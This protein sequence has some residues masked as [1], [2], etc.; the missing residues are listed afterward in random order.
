[1]E[2]KLDQKPAGVQKHARVSCVPTLHSSCLLRAQ[3]GLES[4]FPGQAWPRAWPRSGSPRVPP[5]S[6]LSAEPAEPHRLRP[7]TNKKPN[8]NTGWADAHAVSEGT[9]N[10]EQVRDLTSEAASQSLLP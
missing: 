9:L 4:Q 5:E 8:K 7:P 10:P 1:M 3:T 6:F 2:R